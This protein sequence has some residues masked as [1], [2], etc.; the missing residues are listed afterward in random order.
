M[1]ALAC[2]VALALWATWPLARES[3]TS[4]PLGAITAPTV[5]LFNVWTVWWNA[6]R[7]AHGFHGY[8][9][10]PIFHPQPGTFAF[11]E[12][13]PVTLVVAPLL[14]MSG[15]RALAYN[16]YLWLSLLM[17]AVV[18]ERVLRLLGAR[19]A[20][21]F[22]GGAAM[23][24]LPIVHQQRDV[25]QLIPVWGI[26]WTWIAFHRMGRR[27]SIA[28]GCEL[29]LA[30]SVT[31]GMCIH[32]G[33]FLAVLLA[34]AFWTLWRRL[35]WKRTWL[36]LLAAAAVAAGLLGP[37]LLPMRAALRQH[38]FRRSPDLVVRL[39]ARP[40]DYAALTGRALI[41]PGIGPREP[42]MRLSPGWIKV[43]LAA[44]GGCLGLWRRRWRR[45]TLFLLA[46]GGVAFVCSLG[47]RLNLWGWQPW[48]T[49]SSIVPGLAQARNVFRFAFFVQIAAVLAAMQC[50][51]LLLLLRRRYSSTRTARRI[52]SA[53]ILALGCLAV[54]ETIPA[55]MTLATI[56]DAG[57][58]SAWIDFIR[59]QTP[60]GRSVASIPFASGNDASDFAATTEAMY[61]GT[62]HRTPLVN[63]YSGFFPRE[64]FELR[65]AVNE[66]FPAQ[67]VLRELANRDVEYVIVMPGAPMKTVD[68]SAGDE[69][70]LEFEFEDPMGVQVYRLTAE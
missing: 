36:A 45:W 56:P 30:F 52:A 64:Y 28:R 59:E 16:A 8:W 25:L 51:H 22:F 41:D 60:P 48:S 44:L 69:W 50:L 21:A 24:L 7:A 1:A 17:N 13:Q 33:L 53:A 6:D 2:Y 40:A 18:A 3:T 32:H 63:G 31:C 57:A 49:V 46:T 29:G 10:A 34:G 9:D 66:S 35:L 39:S 11:S 68:W 38:E 4:L 19:R 62:F 42:G 26:L 37:L 67:D 70:S 55:R 54:F 20:A 65:D 27:R 47:L 23:L 43:G 15:S 12:P 5:P 58:H 61:F 14:W